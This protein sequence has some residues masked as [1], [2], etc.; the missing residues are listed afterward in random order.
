[1][2]VLSVDM[3]SSHAEDIYTAL[4][5]LAI[6][7]ESNSA[8]R[9]CEMAPYGPLCSCVVLLNPHCESVTRLQ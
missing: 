6:K 5:R 2:A 3:M 1:M 7:A 8:L 4:R 9:S